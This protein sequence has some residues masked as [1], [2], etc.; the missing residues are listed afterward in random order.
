[1]TRKIIL[2][3]LLLFAAGCGRKMPLPVEEDRGEIPFSGYFVYGSW[4]NVGNVTD[5]LVTEN[6]WLFFAEDSATVTRYRRKGANE[7][8]KLVARAIGTLKDLERPLYLDEGAEDHLV[9]L[10][11]HEEAMPVPPDSTETRPV[12][13]PVVRIYDLFSE[14]YVGSWSDTSWTPIDSFYR[15]PG[16]DSAKS[17]RTIRA[18]TPTAIAA[19][20]EDR[21]YV[22]AFSL[23]YRQKVLR[24]YDTTY[25]ESGRIESLTPIGADTSYADTLQAWSIRAYDARG[26]FL[27]TAAG[28][29]TGL[30]YGR[31]IRDAALSPSYLFFVDGSM[32]RVKVNAARGESQGIEWLDGSEITEPA[33]AV[34]FVLDPSGLAVDPLGSLYLSDGGNGRVLKYTSALRY[35]ERV[36]R[37]AADLLSAPGALAATD[38]LVYVFD[39]AGPK[40]VLFEL[41]KAEK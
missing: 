14:T 23:R 31:E 24:L 8:G 11:L 9:I 20:P 1:M 34:P 19:D 5:I 37:N 18:A 17:T 25:T 7:G 10:D 39:H 38:S 21:V 28:D 4:E 13:R 2:F 36:D 32:G 40:V 12:F 6:Q 41:P 33:E 30:G 29:G 16:R 3:A 27:G 22:T 26:A 15:F 35:R